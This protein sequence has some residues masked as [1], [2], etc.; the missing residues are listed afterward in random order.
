VE[1]PTLNKRKVEIMSLNK[2]PSVAHAVTHAS[3]AEYLHALGKAD[4]TIRWGDTDWAGAR[5]LGAALD[6]ARK[7]WREG[8]ERVEHMAAPI[9]AALVSEVAP[10]G[11]WSADVTGADYDVAEYL[12]GVPECWISPEV[13]VVKPVVTVGINLSVSAIIDHKIIETRGAA[14]VALVQALQAQGHPVRCYTVMGFPADGRMSGPGT[15]TRVN[16]TDDNGGPLD[17]DR[18][19]FAMA[20]TA[21]SRVLGFTAQVLA[22][23]KRPTG[24]EFMGLPYDPPAEVGWKF[25]LYVPSATMGEPQ[26]SSASAARD[27]V[28]ESFT[29]LTQVAG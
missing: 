5:S 27:W 10:T 7:G 23:G 15:F 29:K 3:W 14:V 6:V 22:D 19:A 13:E 11:D 1:H 12:A 8:M 20:H 4:Q 17:V 28:R 25:D 18:L 26:W 24:A 21:A 16:L 2:C 9:L